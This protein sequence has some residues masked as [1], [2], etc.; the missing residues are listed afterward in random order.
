MI[1]NTNNGIQPNEA[2]KEIQVIKVQT[3][4][5]LNGIQKLKTCSHSLSQNRPWIHQ[6]SAEHHLCWYANVDA[7]DLHSVSSNGQH[8]LQFCI[9]PNLLS[10]AKN[11]QFQNM[12][13]IFTFSR[14]VKAGSA[15]A[16]ST[17]HNH[18]IEIFSGGKLIYKY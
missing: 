16:R 1:R 14:F 12:F 10:Y 7:Q 3:K 15:E 11:M 2:I 9:K 5:F 6:H 4:L 17:G 18:F 8:Y 13:F